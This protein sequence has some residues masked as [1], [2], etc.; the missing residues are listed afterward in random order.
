MLTLTTAELPAE[1]VARFW[2]RVIKTDGCWLYNGV[3]WVSQLKVDGVRLY[4]G[5][6][7][8]EED[9][10]RAYDTEAVNHEGF[11]LNFPA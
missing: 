10:A 5:L 1:A 8:S 7:E 9:A 11:Q 4:L 6:F 2:K 3:P